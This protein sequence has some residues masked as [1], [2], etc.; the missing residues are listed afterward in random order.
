MKILLIK[1]GV[2]FLNIIYFFFKLLPIKNKIT[3]ISRQSDA[4]SDDMI[5]IEKSI[6]KKKKNIEMV[7]LCKKLDKNFKSIIKYFLHMFVQMYHLSTSKVIVL[8]SYCIV[9]CVLKKKKNTTIIQMWHAL[10]AFKKFGCSIID[11]EEGTKK[12]IAVAMKMHN[13]YDYVFTSSEY[14]KKFFSEALNTSIDKLVVMPLPRVDMLTDKKRINDIK[15]KIIEKYPCMKNKKNIVYAPTFRKGEENIEKIQ[16]LVN[17]IDYKRYNLIVKLHPLTNIKLESKNAIIDRHFSTL[18]M[19]GCAD[20]VITDYSAIVFEAAI[21]NKPIYFYC[22]DFSKYYKKRNFYLDYKKD[23][24]G[25]IESDAKRLIDLIEKDSYD[26]KKIEKFTKKYIDYEIGKSS[27][28]IASFI[29][30]KGDFK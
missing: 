13:N 17:S 24:P 3:F 9:A 2:F 14:T 22:Y 6:I 16:E 18:D 15:A 23:M 7:F 12:N 20:Y 5:L 10:G 19:L 21:L 26:M 8:D 30:D 4:K 28:N 29:I 11:Q 27:E 1:I 25:I